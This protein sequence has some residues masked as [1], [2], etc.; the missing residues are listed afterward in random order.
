MKFL[1]SDETLL[2]GKITCYDHSTGYKFGT[3]NTNTQNHTNFC[4]L[5][6]VFLKFFV[7]FQVFKPQEAI[8]Y[9]LNFNDRA[10][11]SFL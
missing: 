1:K 3:T 4:N 10:L 7:F 2:R 11:H 6:E 5:F 8:E 9:P